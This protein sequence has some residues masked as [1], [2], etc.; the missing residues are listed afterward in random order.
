MGKQ[1]GRARNAPCA[2]GSGRK[3]KHC[4]PVGQPI[5]G[6][7]GAFLDDTEVDFDMSG[8]SQRSSKSWSAVTVSPRYLQL[9]RD[10]SAALVE[11]YCEKW[12]LDELHW[13]DLLND[14]SLRD[15]VRLTELVDLAWQMAQVL[16]DARAIIVM[17]SA[18]DE[19][20]RD[21]D[22]LVE[23]SRSLSGL[24]TGDRRDDAALF[25]VLFNVHSLAFGNAIDPATDLLVAIDQRCGS[26]R[27]SAGAR[28]RAPFPGFVDDVV[29]VAGADWP[30]VQ[31]ADFAAFSYQRQLRAAANRETGGVYRDLIEPFAVINRRRVSM[32]MT[33]GVADFVENGTPSLGLEKRGVDDHRS[34]DFRI[35]VD[36]WSDRARER[37]LTGDLS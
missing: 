37:F 15:R 7:W 10:R 34:E 13:Y 9:F 18:D 4:H 24:R 3:T 30:E 21:V 14:A 17:Q 22:G 20:F 11:E 1:S 33:S 16:D 25:L 26:G 31:L 19:S 2:C 35:L 12:G 6:T 29:H 8:T 28:P 5:G 32:S 36:A 27:W 23:F